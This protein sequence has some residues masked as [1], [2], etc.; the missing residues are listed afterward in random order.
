MTHDLRGLPADWRR[1]ASAGNEGQYANLRYR[2]E[3]GAS[4]SGEYALHF[5]PLAFR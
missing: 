4:A 1:P 2:K 3:I 5:L